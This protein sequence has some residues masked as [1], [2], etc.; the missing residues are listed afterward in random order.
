METKAANLHQLAPQQFSFLNL[1]KQSGIPLPPNQA[2]LYL[3][4][5]LDWEKLIAA[6]KQL[7][8]T[9]E[10]LRTTLVPMEGMTVPVQSV[11]VGA[12]QFLIDGQNTLLLGE[13]LEPKATVVINVLPHEKSEKIEITLPAMFG[14]KASLKIMAEQMMLFYRG[15]PM[16]QSIVQYGDYAYWQNEILNSIGA[17]DSRLETVLANS[18]LSNSVVSVDEFVRYSRTNGSSRKAIQLEPQVKDQLLSLYECNSTKAEA[19][20]IAAWSFMLANS[21][22]QD[23][24]ILGCV[25]PSRLRE[26]IGNTIGLFEKTIPVQVRLAGETAGSLV[27]LVA[28]CVADAY[29][30]QDSY[31]ASHLFDACADKGFDACGLAYVFESTDLALVN[32]ALGYRM[33]TQGWAE[34]PYKLKLLTDHSNDD[35]RLT[36][37]ANG[38]FL[39]EE[40]SLFEERFLIILN[41]FLGDEALSLDGFE[42]MGQQEKALLASFNSSVAV[43]ETLPTVLDIVAQT[44]QNEPDEVAIEVAGQRVSYA[45]L[46]VRADHIK[47][48]LDEKGVK[49]AHKVAIRIPRSLDFIATTLAVWGLGATAVPVDPNTPVRR[50]SRMLEDAGCLLAV[51]DAKVYSDLG[52]PRV[53]IKELIDI[54]VKS[55]AQF[56]VHNQAEPAFVLF[57]SGSTGVPAGVQVSHQALANYLS[58]AKQEYQVENR[59]DAVWHTSVAFDLSVTSYLL[60][61]VTGSKVIIATESEGITSLVANLASADAAMIVKMTPSHAIALVEELHARGTQYPH[62]HTLVLG[63]E[64]LTSKLV[65]RLKETF[66]HASIF[67]E[68]G[69]T[70]ATVGCSYHRCGQVLTTSNVSI[71]KPIQNTNMFVVDDNGTELPIGSIGEICISGVGVTPG[72]V[73]AEENNAEKFIHINNQRAYR[74][75]DL[76]RMRADGTFEFIG[77][78]DSQVNLRGYRIELEEI[79]RVLSGCQDICSVAVVLGNLKSGRNIVGY[80]QVEGNA[81]VDNRHLF[82]QL[83]ALLPA[84]MMPYSLVELKSL[85][86]TETGKLDRQALA[87]MFV[88]DSGHQVPYVAPRNQVEDILA[89][90]WK[91]VFEVDE[92]GIDENY[93]ELGG[94]SVRSVQVTAL[95]EARGLRFALHLLHENPT[96][97]QLATAVSETQEHVDLY[98]TQPFELLSEEDKALLPAD[99]DDAYPLNLLQEGMI[100]H[101]D[102]A[103]KSAVYHAI[104]SYNINMPI[105]VALMRKAVG[106]LVQQH[107]LLRTSFDLSTFSG[108]TQLVHKEGGSPLGYQDLRGI[109]LDTHQDY[110]DEWMEAEKIRGFEIEEY[111]LIRFMLHHF[112]DEHCQLSYSFHHEIID[113]WSDAMMMTELMNRYLSAVNRVPMEFRLP[114]SSFRDSIYLEHQALKNEKFRDFWLDRIAD[115]NVMKLPNINKLKADKGERDIIKFEPY[116]SKE[117]SDAVKKLSVDLAVPLKTVL[118]AAHLKVMSLMGGHDDVMTYTV[119]NGRPEN[120]DGHAVVGLFVNSLAFRQKLPGGCWVDL[121]KD[122]LKTENELLPYRRY[123]MAELKRQ[124]GSEP[125]AETLFFFNHY[126][127]TDG[128]AR[129]DNAALNDIKVYAESTFPFCVNAFLTPFVKDICIRIEYDALQYR[130]DIMR[131]AGQFYVDVLKAMVA[132]PY[133]NYDDRSF[134]PTE[135]ENTLRNVWS[136]GE[137]V[138]EADTVL[139]RIDTFVTGSPNQA[140]VIDV[141]ASLS[142]GAFGN[143]VNGL[144]GHL[145]EN[146]DTQSRFV[147]ICLNRSA[148]L[149]AAIL[150]VMKAGKAY[151]PINPEYPDVRILSMI[152][153]LGC[154]LICDDKNYVRFVDSDLEQINLSELKPALMA[155]QNDAPAVSI[156]ADSPAYVIYTSG[157]TG[158]PKGVIVNHGNLA[159]STQA[160]LDYYDLQSTERHLLVASA[161]FDSSVAV[162]FGALFSGATLLVAS[163]EAVKDP[164]LLIEFMQEHQASCLLSVPSLL[165][166][167]ID[168]QLSRVGSLNRVISA[169]ESLPRELNRRLSTELQAEVYNEYGPTEA[170]VWSTVYHVAGN[171]D[172]ATVP[173]GKP[174]PGSQVYILDNKMVLVPIG[175]QGEL[176]IGGKGVAAGYLNQPELNAEKFVTNPFDQGQSRLYKTGDVARFDQDGN[177]E[178]V[179]RVDRLVKIQ[180]FRVELSEVEAVLGEHQD[181]QKCIAVASESKLGHK[182]LCAYVLPAEEIAHEVDTMELKEYVKHILPKYMVPSVIMV[183]NQLPLTSSGKLD[184]EHLP[185]PSR[186]LLERSS[187]FVAPRTETE[188]VVAGIW[189]SVLQIERIGANDDFFELGGESLAAMKFMAQ[190][191][192]VYNVSIS[193]GYVFNDVTTVASV[194]AKLDAALSN[195]NDHQ[196]ESVGEMEVGEI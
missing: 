12:L 66:P 35:I 119:G 73:N 96:I 68:Y 177:I 134:L 111:P 6:V 52:C 104:C 121:I 38:A 136:K 1:E 69:P 90:V 88:G 118:L 165:S 170:T 191:R 193:L 10:V 33:E 189:S 150:A 81:L 64:T 183:I 63:G 54:P 9:Q 59:C 182:Y 20:V 72:Y 97:R 7:V 70:E 188:N 42:V 107:P 154:P 122:T 132:D 92:I 190:I 45:Q 141:N 149:I 23:T 48:G 99:I 171:I 55:G 184:Y 158:K 4:K 163:D 40:I 164:T 105:D 144:A 2:T 102:F 16:V 8:E 194:A 195:K 86:K 43:G 94:D 116:F 95:A 161:T 65:F 25:T 82:E 60:P 137:Q 148:D 130:D 143:Y 174:V 87:K 159:A 109:A 67:N 151:V 185:N 53:S 14:D 80:Y 58:W 196:P 76:G 145:V 57:T 126:H 169:G 34:S 15:E 133:T 124:N 176:Y 153:E 167:L 37:S 123:P 18:C 175:V 5:P 98:K 3:S 27:D 115:V 91:K 166:A 49:T 31:S 160:R 11:G 139:K 41:Q 103:P 179:G 39:E 117:L 178:F 74:T 26:G 51:T 83:E 56:D 106:D 46:W 146:T 138:D 32:D 100:Y 62:P 113:G 47:A 24:V 28:Q 162:M 75:G 50:V 79:E 77:R 61:L 147:A 168:E 19:T 180:G 71:G 108:P 44:A 30:N 142:Y 125:L 173:I 155:K 78:S 128:L 114:D 140:A 127:I 156:S 152:K 181:V 13:E 129:W 84:Y 120:R 93:F 21:L 186:F 131:V 17:Q 85:P 36:L 135:M 101:R 187:M 112:S 157:S 192:K 110:V 89:V 22:Q 29:E 172:K